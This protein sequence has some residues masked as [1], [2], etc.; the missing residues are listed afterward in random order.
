M[1]TLLVL[2]LLGTGAHG[3]AGRALAIVPSGDSLV[4]WSCSGAPASLVGVAAA[5][6]LASPRPPLLPA[7]LL[8]WGQTHT[9]LE[10]FPDP[11][12]A[13]FTFHRG[14]SPTNPSH[15]Y[16]HPGNVTPKS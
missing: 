1:A 11:A 10:H 2:T 7:L 15:R 14:D 9:A 6:R 13:A 5:R 4:G 16:H 8:S 3:Q 12:S